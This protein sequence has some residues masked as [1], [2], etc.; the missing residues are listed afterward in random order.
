MGIVLPSFIFFSL[1]LSL[2]PPACLYYADSVPVYVTHTLPAELAVDPHILTVQDACEQL[3]ELLFRMC[4]V[5]ICS[6][7]GHVGACIMKHGSTACCFNS[8]KT[9]FLKTVISPGV[10][11][12]PEFHPNILE[13]GYKI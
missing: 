12:F 3:R 10:S 8:L 5:G 13:Q 6:S 2:P 7:R 9:D 1:S 11:T 4:C